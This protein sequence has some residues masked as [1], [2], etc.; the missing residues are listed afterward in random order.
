MNFENE[1]LFYDDDVEFQEYLNY[2]RRPYTVRTRVDH[3]STWDELDFKNRFRLSKE[4]V[5]MILNMIGPTISSN[6]DR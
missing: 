6:T 3:F 2:Q 1:I 5:L 4:T